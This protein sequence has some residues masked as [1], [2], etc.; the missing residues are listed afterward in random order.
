MGFL[1]API[2]IPWFLKVLRSVPPNMHSTDT[3]TII[4]IIRENKQLNKFQCSFYNYF[5]KKL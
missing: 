2:L 4:I 1:M 5:I 3:K